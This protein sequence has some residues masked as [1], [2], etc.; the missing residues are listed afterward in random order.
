MPNDIHNTVDMDTKEIHI[1]EK[2]VEKAEK[3][4]K[5]VLHEKLGFAP[6]VKVKDGAV[7]V[8]VDVKF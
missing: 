2:P 4:L 3:P 7:I 8:G 5:E 6:E 1:A